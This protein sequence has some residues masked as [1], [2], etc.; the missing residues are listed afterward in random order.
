MKRQNN[1]TLKDGTPQVSKRDGAKVKTIPSCRM[2]LVMVHCGKEQ[3]CRGTWNVR[4][5]NQDK[6]K[7]VKQEIAGVNINILG[8]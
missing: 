8:I 7:V 4:C 6:L 5:M 1:T 2:W 3:Y